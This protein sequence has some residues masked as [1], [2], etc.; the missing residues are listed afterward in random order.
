MKTT[1]TSVARL[2]PLLTLLAL[3]PISPLGCADD[4]SEVN[5]PTGPST[6]Y[7]P[8]TDLPGAT[9]ALNGNFSV[10]PGGG[11][12]VIAT[13][14][15]AAG[16][17]VNGVPLVIR[18]ETGGGAVAG[19]FS[20]DT[21][22]TLTDGAGRASIHVNVSATCPRGSYRLVVRT[23]PAGPVNAPFA[24]AYTGVM[25]EGVGISIVSSV[26]LTT[27]TS[28][29]TL[30]NN[31]IFNAVAVAAGT[32]QLVMEYQAA[33]AGIGPTSWTSLGGPPTDNPKLFSLTPTSVGTLTVLV[34][35]Y[36][37][38]NVAGAVTSDSVA[39]TVAPATP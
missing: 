35:A 6:Q 5:D 27:S 10:G 29:V 25:V 11:F 17:A 9:I 39:V 30:P 23:F 22:P 32:C 31:A 37:V 34:R 28:S 7:N 2:L 18:A 12:D 38:G 8:V 16:V 19:Y 4:G 20:F 21:N 33:G 15:N 1:R 24:T 36:C 3:L 26:S 14:R 13:F